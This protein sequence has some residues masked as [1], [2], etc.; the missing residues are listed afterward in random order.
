MEGQHLLRGQGLVLLEA[1]LPLPHW[2][3]G[4][5]CRGQLPPPPRAEPGSAGVQG[6]AAQGAMPPAL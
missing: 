1:R 2:S 5:P 6:R 4:S 3:R